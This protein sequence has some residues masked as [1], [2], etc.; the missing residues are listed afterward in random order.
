MFKKQGRKTL[1]VLVPIRLHDMFNKLC[2]D[3]EI[4]KTQAIIRYLQYL[5]AKPYEKRKLLYAKSKPDFKLD[6][7]E[8]DEL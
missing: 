6:V 2:I 4:S 3:H 5:Q 7:G 1:S 8:P